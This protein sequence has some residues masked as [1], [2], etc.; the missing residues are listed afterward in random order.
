VD[1]NLTHN[2]M[3]VTLAVHRLRG[4]GYGVTLREKIES[5]TGKSI[6]YGTLYSVLDRLEKRGFVTSKMGEATKERGGRRKKHYAITGEGVSA[7]STALTEVDK[8][9]DRKVWARIS[10]KNLEKHSAGV[11]R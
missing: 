2:E 7:M 5:E 6:A 8:L 11:I 1:V 10:I 3:L 9:R 4:D